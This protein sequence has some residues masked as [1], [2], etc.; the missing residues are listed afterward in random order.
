MDPIR[1]EVIRNALTAVT[2]VMGSVLRRTAHSTNVKTRAD[3]SCVLFDAQLRTVAHLSSA[4]GLEA[5][6]HGRREGA[7]S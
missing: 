1:I 4:R 7:R 3:F 5:A 6:R 2:E